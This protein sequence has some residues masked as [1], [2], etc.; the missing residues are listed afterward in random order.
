MID[1][2]V[3]I[4]QPICDKLEVLPFCQGY[5]LS[6]SVSYV[7]VFLNPIT[8][9]LACGW[10]LKRCFSQNHHE[11]QRPQNDELYVL[12]CTFP[13]EMAFSF[14]KIGIMIRDTT[15]RALNVSNDV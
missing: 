9:S 6:F 14:Q 12:I 15:I 4:K 8:T 13:H 5:A 10:G 11:Q 7:T 3:C 2:T 1:D